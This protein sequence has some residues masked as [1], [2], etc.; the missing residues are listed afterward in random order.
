MQAIRRIT[1]SSD[2]RLGKLR[3]TGETARLLR[4]LHK[5]HRL[6]ELSVLFNKAKRAK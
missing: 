6:H 4:G 2:M 5:Q 3:V 1:G